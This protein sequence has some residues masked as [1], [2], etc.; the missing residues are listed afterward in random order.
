MG[1]Y[2]GWRGEVVPESVRGWGRGVMSSQLEKWSA[3]AADA[4]RFRDREIVESIWKGIEDGMSSKGWSKES[5]PV[6]S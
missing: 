1:V 5:G 6:V 3:G 2:V 4:S